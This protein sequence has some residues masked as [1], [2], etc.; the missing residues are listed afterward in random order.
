MAL[1]KKSDIAA[2]TL[3]EEVVEVAELGGQV[4]VRGLYLHERLELALRD[5]DGMRRIA[6][7]LALCVL[8]AD[9]APLWSAEEWTLFGGRHCEAALNLWEIAKRLSG[10]DGE[11][12]EK[13]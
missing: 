8:D 7:M 10:M 5:K 4:I 6:Q 2:P 9:R 12:A 3:H 11:G 13:N 1:L